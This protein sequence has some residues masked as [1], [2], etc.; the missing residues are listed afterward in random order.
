MA[1]QQPNLFGTA[2]PY[3]PPGVPGKDRP[4]PE[5]SIEARFE[6]F[7]AEHP[8]VY[9]EFVRIALDLRRRGREHYSAD[10]VCHVIRFERI[11]SGKDDDGWKL[12]N[13]FTA[14]LARKAMAEHPEELGGLFETRQRRAEG[15]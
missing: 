10:A 11:T 1:D 9:A 14:L 5:S 8:D 4:E 3:E 12:N 7:L 6:K 15:A 2:G 13:S